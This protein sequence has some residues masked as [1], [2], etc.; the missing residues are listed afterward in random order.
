MKLYELSD[1]M[2]ED[3]HLVCNL[4]LKVAHLTTRLENKSDFYTSWSRSLDVMLRWHNEYEY[5]EIVSEC[6]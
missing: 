1:L 4:C 5:G 3:G 2:R 6:F